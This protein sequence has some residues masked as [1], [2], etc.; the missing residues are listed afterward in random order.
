[1]VSK[2]IGAEDAVAIVISSDPVAVCTGLPASL[3]RA[4][5]LKVPPAVGV[6][7]MAPLEV[8][9]DKPAGRDPL[10]MDHV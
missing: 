10:A 1:L 6:P 4:V 5:K 2:R 7:A 9:S 3:T 8:L